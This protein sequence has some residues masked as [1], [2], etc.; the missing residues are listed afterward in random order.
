M[1][2]HTLSVRTHRQMSAAQTLTLPRAWLR[3]TAPASRQC[4]TCIGHGCN[5]CNFRGERV[6]SRQVAFHVNWE[7]LL[8]AP[9]RGLRTRRTAM[10][11]CN[12]NGYMTYCCIDE[13]LVPAMMRFPDARDAPWSQPGPCSPS[14]ASTP[15]CCA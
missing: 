15:S 11:T 14:E 13:R 12:G 1:S 4:P 6:V 8:E 9:T 7:P 5:M 10:E 3:M 2:F